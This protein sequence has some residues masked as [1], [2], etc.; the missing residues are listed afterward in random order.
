MSC[1]LQ[2]V[3]T[4][5]HQARKWYS[6]NVL[7][8]L[9]THFCTIRSSSWT[10]I[11]KRIAAEESDGR[12]ICQERRRPA[13]WATCSGRERGR[14]AAPLRLEF[15]HVAEAALVH[16]RAR[17]LTRHRAKLLARPL[18]NCLGLFAS[19]VF[20]LKSTTIN[21]NN[22]CQRRARADSNCAAQARRKSVSRNPLP[23]GELAV[24]RNWRARALK[25]QR[26][27]RSPR[28]APALRTRTRC[29]RSE[30]SAETRTRARPE[31]ELSI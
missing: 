23:S 2:T 10:A 21:S 7:T 5:F 27:A 29:T 14:L 15:A 20:Q 31:R 4:A 11:E 24:A 18:C 1:S 26:Q 28:G 13:A 3:R 12:L 25:Y 19:S 9:T 8:R 30:R 6:S 17:F 22:S 16:M